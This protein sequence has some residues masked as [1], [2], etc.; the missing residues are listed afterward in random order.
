MALICFRHL[1][2]LGVVQNLENAIEPQYAFGSYIKIRKTL[3]RLML[4]L[5]NLTT[6]AEIL[7]AEGHIG[8]NKRA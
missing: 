6:L 2:L 7:L 1:G 3:R 5:K 4:P 8:H